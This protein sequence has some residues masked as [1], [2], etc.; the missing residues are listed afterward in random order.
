MAWDAR[1]L[2]LAV[3]ME[4]PNAKR[5]VANVKSRDGSV[6][7]DDSAELFITP[8]P[9]RKTYFHFVANSIGTQFD[10][11]VQSAVWN[12]SWQAAV[13][14]GT[15]YWSLECAIPVKAIGFVPGEGKSLWGNVNRTR[16]AGGGEAHS[17]WTP[18]IGGFHDSKRFGTFRLMGKA[19]PDAQE[20]AARMD[21]LFRE[22]MKADMRRAWEEVLKRSEVLAAAEKTKLLHKD[23]LRLKQRVEEVRRVVEKQGLLEAA[24]SGRITPTR[25]LAEELRT[26]EYRARIE[27]LLAVP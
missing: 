2:Y 18:L 17:T 22:A 1:N 23:A 19:G 27:Q 10:E 24:L 7:K 12:A 20:V 25:E 13:K 21:A 3:R 26:L 8:E 14:T 9:A 6:W 5:L 16:C 15:G 4:E 11:E